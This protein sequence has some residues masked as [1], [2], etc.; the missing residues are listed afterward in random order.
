[1]Q[2]GANYARRSRPS[3]PVTIFAAW[4]RVPYSALNSNTSSTNFQAKL[5]AIYRAIPSMYIA[6]K[7]FGNYEA[8][9][10]AADVHSDSTQAYMSCAA[11]RVE[12]YIFQG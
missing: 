1:M 2:T 4:L 3:F 11:D 8:L 6:Q 12:T 5:R 10:L 9:F 7:L